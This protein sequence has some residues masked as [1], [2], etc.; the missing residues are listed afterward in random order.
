MKKIC[1]LVRP[2][3]GGIMEQVSRLVEHFSV[4]CHVV[5][6]AYRGSDLLAREF[7][8]KVR[9]YNLQRASVFLSPGLLIDLFV[10]WGILRRER[11]DLLHIHGHA[12]SQWGCFVAFM[13]GVPTVVTVHGFPVLPRAS[14]PWGRLVRGIFRAGEK[15]RQCMTVRYICVSRT[16]ATYMESFAGVQ[17]E[18]LA[19]IHNGVDPSPFEDPGDPAFISAKRKELSGG[20]LGSPPAFS[21]ANRALPVIKGRPVGNAFH[22]GDIKEGAL[23]RPG[24]GRIVLV[25][26]VARLA[27]QKGI[28][29][30]LRAAS[31]LV[32]DF[33]YLRFT[34]VG[35]GPL[36]KELESLSR[37]LGL[38][39]ELYF[40]GYQDDLPLVLKALDIFVLPST[41]E[42]L[43]ITALE[44]LSASLPVAASHTGGIPEIVQEEETGL[45]FNP[46]DDRELSE[47]IKRLL[48]EP[49]LGRVLGKEGRKKVH[50][51]F[52]LEAMFRRT[53]LVYR[54][55]LNRRKSR[56][57]A[58]RV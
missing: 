52:T 38:E 18:K 56:E 50:R 22:Q 24:P 20:D 11:P 15:I 27:P 57:K 4:D 3:A 49:E 21:S 8:E 31:R 6:V 10:F 29:V 41:S 34:V 46:G 55:A 51:S 13:A 53:G 45:L 14:S 48:K 12:A 33:P 26:T 43:S 7:D 37:E 23:E 44:A 25:G 9:K 28:E 36:R 5:L 35:D 54:E 17:K 47:K 1:Y 19:V 42:G 58:K 2:C 40:A 39:K 30:F 32:S 16:L